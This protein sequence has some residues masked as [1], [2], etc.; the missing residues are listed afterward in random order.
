MKVAGILERKAKD[1]LVKAGLEILNGKDPEKSLDKLFAIIKKTVG[2]SKS[3]I[4]MSQIDKVQQLYNE[5][6]AIHKLVVDI[7]SKT[8]KNCLDKFFVNF[9]A[10]AAWYGIP[11]REALFEKTGTKVPFTILISPSMRCNL[12]C[13]G[14][15]A[16]SYS[17]KDDIPLEELDRII[18]EARDLGVYYFVILGGEPFI[19][20]YMLDL[21]EK[22]NDCMFTPFSN[23]TLFTEE[24]A[25]RLQK[26][27]NVIPMFS[28]EGFEK[29]TDERRGKGVFQK[30]MH[31]MD[32]L[33]ERGIL[34]GV[35]SA[36]GRHN[37]DTVTSDEFIDML[38]EKGARMTWY[39]LFMPV[40]KE[41]D[42]S[43]MLTPEQRI[44]LG[45]RV[46]T[47][48]TTKPYFTL[49]FFNDAPYVGGCIAGK[50]Y[51]HIN[52]KEDLEPC[53][54]A[55]FAVDNVKGKKLLDVF[56]SEFFKLLR[57][58]QPY[59]RN[60]LMPCMM[61]DNTK[62][63]RDIVKRTG[64]RPTDEGARMMLED[65]EFQKKLD[66]LSAEFRPYAEKA[67]KEEFGEKGNFEMS[68]G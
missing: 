33:K 49:D 56:G 30:V 28:L 46:R 45:E 12:R 50:Y 65:P 27:G 35:S 67:W 6:P 25:D 51:C 57:D 40:G 38:I 41:P 18:G 61:I 52:S 17:K 36:T 58:R 68:K 39:F 9:F 23:S 26:L 37:I 13:T 14:C 3:K 47:L 32:L 44:R 11:K 15:Y 2:K 48:R 59:N 53:I 66:N 7:V 4:S 20:D 21:Y 54:F 64:A 10:N 16:S 43:L 42:T 55:H 8:N 31:A 1:T 29:E 62:Q 22:Y 60:L 34:F 24:V 19:N 5:N 63:V